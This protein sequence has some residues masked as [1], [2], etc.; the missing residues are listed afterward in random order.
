MIHRTLAAALVMQT[1]LLAM[2]LT[3]LPDRPSELPEIWSAQAVTEA[4]TEPAVQQS[5]QPADQMTAEQPEQ[6]VDQPPTELPTQPP[7]QPLPEQVRVLLPDGTVE[8]MGLE[9]YLWGVVAAEMPAAFE[10]EALKAQAVAARSYTLWQMAHPGTA[11]PQAEVCCDY[12]CCQAWVSRQERLERWPEEE[13]ETYARKIT[14]A[15]ADTAGQVLTWEGE[16][17]LAVFHASCAGETHSALQ[18]WGQD[19]PYLVS[20][21]SPE[22][23]GDAP[24][25]YSVVS[26]TPEEFRE[27]AQ[28]A[29]P[30]AVLGEDVSAWVR[31]DS[32]DSLTIGG[33]TLP[34][35]EVRQAFGL[36][37]ASFTVECDADG[38]RFY[39]TGYGHGVGM[40]QYG[41]N[42]MARG[43]ADWREIL[44]HYYPGTELIPP[45]G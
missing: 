43:G 16:P 30:G 20:V 22:G 31:Q 36:R 1:L 32:P 24:N 2:A 10:P 42:V 37:S 34:A 28:A 27:K 23:E 35:V 14:Q 26:L 21:S 15:V 33:V 8:A 40:S 5:G 44:D 45:C 29:C 11:H 3:A 7:A 17:A 4:L 25:Y 41:A 6:P 39:V 9:D 12:A 38:V 18:V 19:I 13:R